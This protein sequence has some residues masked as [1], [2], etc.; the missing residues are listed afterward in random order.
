MTCRILDDFLDELSQLRPSSQQTLTDGIWA[1]TTDHF[2]QNGFDKLILID[3]RADH[4]MLL[5]TLP[6]DWVTRYHEEGY[7]Q[8]DPFFSYCGTT[9]HPVSTGVAYAD[10]HRGLNQAQQNL[11]SEAAEFGIKAGFSSTVKRLGPDG[12][13]GWNIG[14]SLSRKEVDSLRRDREAALR[15]AAHH[16]YNCL[17]L[18]QNNASGG[19]LSSRERQCLTLL[20][21]GQRTKEIARSLSLSGAAVELYTRNARSK[22][23]ATTREQ[24][25]AIAIARGLLGDE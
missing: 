25:V 12:F 9:Y 22:L 20:A 10:Q 3:Q 17:A 23:G 24:A 13:A 19:P 1:L 4:M 8:I 18:E 16:A 21:Q 6:A 2:A 11:I 15:L 7:A 5:S 14:S